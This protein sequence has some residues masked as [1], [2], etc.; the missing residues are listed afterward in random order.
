MKVIKGLAWTGFRVIADDKL[1]E[2]VRS[3]HPPVH[4]DHLFSPIGERGPCRHQD[5]QEVVAHK[6]GT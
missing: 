6:P 3:L 5:F 2:Q 1:Y 4:T